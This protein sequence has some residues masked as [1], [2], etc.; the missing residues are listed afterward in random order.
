MLLPGNQKKVSERSLCIFWLRIC[1]QSIFY[2]SHLSQDS[3]DHS[4][5]VWCVQSRLTVEESDQHH[6]KKTFSNET[7]CKSEIKQYSRMTKRRERIAKKVPK[8]SHSSHS[9]SRE[10]FGIN[11]FYKGTSLS[12][13]FLK[14]LCTSCRWGSKGGE[15]FNKISS[16]GIQTLTTHMHSREYLCSK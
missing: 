2:R 16:K 1:R 9:D 6:Q 3:E 12:R 4:A 8:K 13:R 10:E 14:Q 5:F 15:K 7:L 11:L